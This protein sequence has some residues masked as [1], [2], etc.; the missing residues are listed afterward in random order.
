MNLPVKLRIWAAGHSKLSEALKVT[1]GF[2]L[3]WKGISFL[4][5]LDVLQLYLEETGINDSLGLSAAINFLAQLIIIL[6]LF[7]GICIAL[8]IKTRLFCWFNLPI[9]FGA[10]FLV[11][12]QRGG[13]E[14]RLDFWLSLFSLLAIIFILLTEKKARSHDRHI[15]V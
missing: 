1:L 13:F 3:I 11:N 5:N 4:L 15:A 8:S 2:I 7:G 12:M 10:V 14:P 6:N 9:V